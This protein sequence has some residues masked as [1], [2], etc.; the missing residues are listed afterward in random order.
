MIF[1]AVLKHTWVRYKSKI[2]YL[3]ISTEKD[4]ECPRSY[5]RQRSTSKIHRHGLNQPTYIKANVYRPWTADTKH[6][7]GSHTHFILNPT[8]PYILVSRNYFPVCNCCC[9][10]NTPLTL[11]RFSFLL[12][13]SPL[14]LLKLKGK[15]VV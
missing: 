9:A 6:Q 8:G 12:H 3:C 15:R 1:Q 4:T 10:N 5:K 7:G 11:S 14:D 13:T 2:K